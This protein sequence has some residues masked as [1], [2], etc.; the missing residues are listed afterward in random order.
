[1]FSRLFKAGPK[2][3][4]PLAG[5]LVLLIALLDWRIVD[6][7][8]LGFL[9]LVPMLL[10]GRVLRPWQTLVIAALCTALSEL[11]DPYP[12]SVRAGL[13]RDVLYFAAFATIGIF[14]Y[15][16]SRSRQVILEHLAEIERERGAREGAEEDLR[17]LIESSP[18]A[19]LTADANGTILMANEAAHRLLAATPGTLPG[20][21]VQQFFPALANIQRR[22]TSQRLFRAVMQSRGHRQ[23]NE[24]FMADICF[25]TYETRSGARLAAL[26]L[27]ASEEMRSREESSLQQMLAGSRIAVSAVSH[28]IRNVC[29]A[30]SVVHQNLARRQGPVKDQEAAGSKDFEALGNL[31]LA[32][33]KIAGVDLRVYPET[34][35]ELDLRSVLDDLKIVIGPALHDEGIRCTWH[36]EPDLPTVWA[37][38][39][40]LMQIFLNLA[41]NGVRAL[42]RHDGERCLSI[43]ARLTDH[44]VS[45]EFLDSGG[46][47][48]RPQELFRPFQAAAQA[49]GLGLYL[50]RAFA[51]S[52]GGELRYVPLEGRACFIVDLAV[53]A[54]LES[55]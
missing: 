50:S 30:I 38:R 4:L 7:L 42:S 40:N 31:V 23:D 48:R 6:D 1:M 21:L 16:M 53:A 24:S 25:S 17:I 52:F 44:G 18:A 55:R 10:V 49:T 5:G 2:V 11:F 27:D 29:G 26:I 41:N 19:I 35:T 20:Y 13:P 3:I 34:C 46:G 8:P 22:E 54:P 36:L 9:Y 28:E 33:E 51:R 12:W 39:T 45:V 15:E 43:S 32:L 37:D 47:V 14:V